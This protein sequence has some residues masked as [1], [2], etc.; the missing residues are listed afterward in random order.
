MIRK[1][2]WPQTLRELELFADCD[3]AE[4]ERIASLIT[5]AQVDAG[6]VLLVERAHDRQF[7]IIA[8]GQLRVTRGHGDDERE[9][10]CLGPGDF[11]GEMSLLDRSPRSAT[12][13]A[14]TKA[15]VY[16]CNAQEFTALLDASRSVAAKITSAA[17]HRVQSNLALGLTTTGP[18]S[19][20]RITTA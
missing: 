11:V 9:L 2:S 14:V 16:A 17:A 8:E 1:P 12:V 3:S 6:D 19:E 7:I 18:P 5:S 10:A 13:T 20:S 15:T 4:L